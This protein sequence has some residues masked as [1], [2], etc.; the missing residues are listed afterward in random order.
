MAPN[1]LATYLAS[2]QTR[3]PDRSGTCVARLA[4]VLILAFPVTAAAFDKSLFIDP[5]DGMLDA[6]RY[7][8]ERPGSFLPVPVVITEPAVGYG[9]GL[10]GVFFHESEE[11]KAQRLA[12]AAEEQQAILPENISLAA[13]GATENGSWFAGGGHLGFWKKD[14]LRY[15]G[16]VGLGSFNLEFYSLGFVDLERPVEL[17]IDGPAVFQELKWR[18]GDSRWFVGPRQVYRRVETSLHGDDRTLDDLPVGAQEEIRSLFDHDVKTSALGLAIEYDS[19]DNTFN[20]E[21]GYHYMAHYDLFDDA[22]DS[23]VNFE[24]Y[25]LE[26]LHYWR[27]PKNFGLNFRFQYDGLDAADDERLPPYVPP[28][29]DLRGIAAAR[30]QGN[31][32]G[33]LELQLNWKLHTRWVFSIFGGAGR[34]ADRFGDLQEASSRTTRGVGFRYLVA[35]RYGF[36]MGLDLAQG[37]EETSLY[38]QAGSTW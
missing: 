27:L 12:S 4:A 26:G 8:S 25:R 9:L 23:D 6:S 18:L 28:Y 11:Q 7:L 3:S 36:T 21:R 24:A 30:Y 2:A 34:A 16:F 29:I 22:L 19:R 17:N 10:A 33:L 1:R 37:P 20:P 32:V 13:G 31:A 15:K 14:S 38:I 5:D 35:K